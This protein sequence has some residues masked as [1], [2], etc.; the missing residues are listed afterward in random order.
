MGVTWILNTLYKIASFLNMSSPQ[1]P[2]QLILSV[3]PY[4]ACIRKI[5]EVMIIQEIIVENKIIYEF[6]HDRSY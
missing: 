2:L 4:A 1:F 5:E 6:N 3:Q